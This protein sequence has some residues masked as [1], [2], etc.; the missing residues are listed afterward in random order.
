MGGIS[1]GGTLQGE[2]RGLKKGWSRFEDCIEGYEELLFALGWLPPLDVRRA[3]SWSPYRV[4]RRIT[5]SS[6]T[7]P[8]SIETS[9]SL[10]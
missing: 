7:H 6:S 9:E 10:E 1:N 8:N 2:R 3:R 4:I 5:Q